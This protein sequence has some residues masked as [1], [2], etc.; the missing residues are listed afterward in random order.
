MRVYVLGGEVLAAVKRT[1]E[2]DFRSNFSLGGKAEIIDLPDEVKEYIRLI[3]E[4]LSPDLVGIDFI[5]HNGEWV[6]GEIEDV[7]GTRMLYALTDIDAADEYV[8]YVIGQINN[9]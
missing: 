9:T 7:V 6:L 5:R 4:A 3:I 2:C 1:S 8:G